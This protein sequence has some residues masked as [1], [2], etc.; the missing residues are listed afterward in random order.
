MSH[1]VSLKE[2]ILIQAK[3]FFI[4]KN[5]KRTWHIPFLASL[6]VG[7][8]LFIGLYFDTLPIGLSASM[9]GLVILY[10]QPTISLGNR[11]LLMIICS[12]GF[13]LSLAIGLGF[14]FNPYVSSVVLGFFAMGINWVTA[15]FKTKP[16]ANFFFIMIAS[17]A[18][19]QPYNLELIPQKIGF[20]FLGTMLACFLAL[21]H[22]LLTMKK[23]QTLEAL[24]ITIK[25]GQFVSLVESAVIGIFIFISLFIGHFFKLQN[26]YWI[27]ISCLAILQG[28]SGQHILE[29]MIHRIVGTFIGM[30]LCWILLSYC[31]SPISICAS[32][33]ILLFIAEILIVKNYALAIIFIT[34]MTILMT[35]VGSSFTSNVAI[36]IPARFLDITIGSILGAIGGWFLYNQKFKHKAVQHLRKTRIIIRKKL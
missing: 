32:I 20:I 25:K 19:F 22:G 31:E 3:S 23:T 2:T 30:G 6:C 8:P 35:E 27:P 4:L 13:P 34:P 15:Y 17:M 24:T 29:R 26:P 10:Y 11:M 21:C 7:I 12:F 14:S 33:F 36:I 1:F 28:I 16:P 18:S 5:N 9:G